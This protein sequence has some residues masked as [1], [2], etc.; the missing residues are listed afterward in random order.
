MNQKSTVLLALFMTL[1]MMSHYAGKRP[2][3]YVAAL[4]GISLREAPN[5]KAPKI[6]TLAYGTRIS[7]YNIAEGS[8]SID[9]Y[10]ASWLRVAVNGKDGYI[11]GGYTIPILPPAPNTKDIFAYLKEAVGEKKASD[12]LEMGDGS[13]LISHRYKMNILYQTAWQMYG[14]E[15]ALINLNMSVQEAYLLCTLIERNVGGIWDSYYYEGKNALPQN[16]PEK[17]YKKDKISVMSRD[18]GYF[19]IMVDYYSLKIFRIQTN[20]AIVWSIPA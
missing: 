12:S 11:Y 19:E 2:V 17:G 9:G 1:F 14:M 13:S 3:I 4:S 15:T 16:Y 18:W 8:N 20:V 6:E 7:N 5:K 10:Y